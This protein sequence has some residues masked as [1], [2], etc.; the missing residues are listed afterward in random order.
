[1]NTYPVIYFTFYIFNYLALFGK[2]LFSLLIVLLIGIVCQ[3]FKCPSLPYAQ[4]HRKPDDITSCLGY[5]RAL[6]KVS[7]S[8]A[9]M[10]GRQTAAA[11]KLQTSTAFCQQTFDFGN[12]SELVFPCSLD[13]SGYRVCGG[14]SRGLTLSRYTAA[15]L[16][17]SL[18]FSIKLFLCCELRASLRWCAALRRYYYL[19]VYFII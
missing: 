16:S 7:A 18:T 4:E 2:N 5:I 10:N 17:K 14:S 15:A 11:E 19:I 13:A 9:D 3:A 12:L 8:K 1:M 6:A